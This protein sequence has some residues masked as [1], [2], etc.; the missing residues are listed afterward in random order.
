M[1]TLQLN[2]LR[3]Y[4]ENEIICPEVMREITH[5][6]ESRER[7]KLTTNI[8]EISGHVCTAIATVLAF[9]SGVYAY[10]VLAYLSGCINIISLIL[11]RFS[12]YTE[13]ESRN[14]NDK[15]NNIFIKLNIN[16]PIY[17]L[18][19]PAHSNIVSSERPNSNYPHTARNSIC[20][21]Y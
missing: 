8:V 9:S 14:R 7:W 4:V 16:S 2:D 5:L 18:R 13:K 3:Q 20:E 12:S 10:V 11:F 17:S 15:L 21:T 19:S 6:I 1:Q